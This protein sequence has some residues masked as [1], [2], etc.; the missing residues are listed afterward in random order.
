MNYGLGSFNQDLPGFVVL[1]E[2]SYPQGGAANW[3]NGYLPANF[4]GTPL[5]AKGSPILDL[6]PP[7]G[8]SEARQR[9]NLDLI[10]KLNTAH[11]AQHPGH[12]EL[13]ARMDN[14]ELAFRMQM[15]VPE[16][17]D[18]SKEDSFLSIC[19]ARQLNKPPALSFSHPCRASAG[20]RTEGVR[21]AKARAPR[22]PPHAQRQKKTNH[23]LSSS[24]HAPPP[25][26]QAAPPPWWSCRPPIS[27]RSRT[28]KV[29]VVEG[30]EREGGAGGR[31]PFFCLLPLSNLNP[32]A[33]TLFH[34]SPHSPRRR[35]GPHPHPRRRSP[36]PPLWRAPGLPAL[37]G[38]AGRGRG[39]CVGSQSAGLAGAGS[40]RARGKDCLTCF[41]PRS[42][43]RPRGPADVLPVLPAPGQPG[44]GP[45]GG[46]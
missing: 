44:R 33:R 5:R 34:F 31:T 36:R 17:L 39:G 7:P 30:R 16:T 35:R 9:K 42:R 1:P 29:R 6:T 40:N 11:A 46:L 24:F 2:V 10:T 38:D 32:R 28:C 22:I 13:A 18:L 15:Q 43:R 19:P 26:A 45:G 41:S 37:L 20:A 8:V 3:S 23:P 14:Y 4:Q 27:A 21:G 12:D 25:P